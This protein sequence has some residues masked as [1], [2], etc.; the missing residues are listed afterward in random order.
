[1]KSLSRALLIC[2]LLAPSLSPSLSNAAPPPGTKLAKEQVFHRGNH[3]EPQSLDPHKS[4]GIPASRIQ[5]GIF[6]GLMRDGIDSAPIP[7]VAESWTISDDSLVY[8]FKLRK[9]AL[10]S[11]GDPV[12][13]HDFEY[14]WKRLLNPKT[15]S[16]YS[17]TLAPVL[18]AEAIIKGEIPPEK[19]AIKVIDK[20]TFEVTLKGPTPYFLGLLTHHSTYPVHAASIKK[21]GD[22]HARPGTLVSNG[23][24]TLK[25]WVVQSHITTVRNR[26]YWDDANTTLEKV[27]YYPTENLSTELKRYRAGQLHFTEEIPANQIRWVKKNL[28]DDIHIAPWLG[29]YYYGYNLTKPPFKDNIK[30]RQ[31]LSMAIDREIITEKVLPF[32]IIPAYGWVPPGVRDYKQEQEYEWKKLTRKE[33]HA[34][35]KKLYQ[36][37]GYSKSNPLK[38]EIRYNTH[39]NHK[40]LAVAIASMWKKVLG[41]KVTLVNEEWKVFLDNR[42]LKQVTQ[43][44]RA[45]W[46]ADYNDAVSFIELLHSEH[47]INDSAY[48]NP[49]YDK[50]VADSF[51]ERDPAKRA[52]ILAKAEAIALADFPTIPIYYYT[53]KHLV[54]PF[55]G[56]YQDNIMDFHPDRYIYIKQH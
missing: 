16:Y 35:A 36:E 23:A 52:K 13:A 1:M 45:G 29:T 27:V 32:G 50:L 6:E 30:L 19:L 24:F 9:N 22:S 25:E 4:E 54:K 44:F 28:P 17:Q 11:N 34:M 43:V 20:H 55:I 21:H 18:N 51:N 8:T 31:A 49:E 38:T 33:R 56:G 39:E 53:S 37:A 3:T 40:R 14:A 47:G 5:R 12:T 7:G 26:K 48:N 10:W 41:I 42:K 2:T 46:I 15:G